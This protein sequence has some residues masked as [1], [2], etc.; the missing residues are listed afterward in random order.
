MLQETA[1]GVRVEQ[2][3]AETAGVA[4]VYDQPL[5]L[6][7]H[8]PVRLH[9]A[10]AVP[11]GNCPSRLIQSRSTFFLRCHQLPFFGITSKQF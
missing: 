8:V 4:G 5:L 7:L 10:Q 11:T 6:E 9:R 1:G 3:A 2:P